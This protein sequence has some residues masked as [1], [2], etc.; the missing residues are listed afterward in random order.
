MYTGE[1]I[2][3]HYSRTTCDMISELI[4]IAAWFHSQAVVQ[5]CVC[6]MYFTAVCGVTTVRVIGF[7]SELSHG[8]ADC[9]S[10]QSR[11]RICVKQL[12]DTQM[13]ALTFRVTLDFQVK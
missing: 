8:L 2:N 3:T 12:Y 1:N 9:T 6:D 11:R 5:L 13:Y 7:E 4:T 10:T